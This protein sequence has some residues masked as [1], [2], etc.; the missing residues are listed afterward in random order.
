MPVRATKH[1]KIDRRQFG[2]LGAFDPWLDVDSPLFVDPTLLEACTIPEFV[3]SRDLVLAHYDKI[4]RLLLLAKPESRLWSEAVRL[5]AFHEMPGLALGYSSASTQGGGIGADLAASIVATAKEIIDAGVE[6]PIIFEIVGLFEK[7][8]GPDRISDMTCRIL[9]ERIYAFS[10]RVFGQFPHV[11]KRPF[12]FGGRTYSLP[13]NPF[14]HQPVL[15]V[16]SGILDELPLAVDYDGIDTVCSFNEALR[17]R[18][19]AL[20]GADW[21]KNARKYNKPELKRFLLSQPELLKELVSGYR[22]V[23]RKSYDF[24]RDVLGEFLLDEV[25]EL[26]EAKATEFKALLSWSASPTSPPLD[27]VKEVCE[28]VK[29]MVE[30]K[31]MW[32]LLYR[33][34]AY[35]EPKYEE[36]AQILFGGL[37]EEICNRCDVDATREPETGRG[38]V[39]FKFSRGARG[40]VLVETKLSTN[41][42]LVHA[43]DKQVQIYQKAAGGEHSIIVVFIVTEDDKHVK[44]LID[45]ANNNQVPGKTPSIILIDALPKPSASKA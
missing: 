34:S 32:K 44:K 40:K 3:D 42:N 17:D 33:D 6:D 4:F 26:F 22:M 13:L 14:K 23:K 39:D 15:L 2:K 38:P 12:T 36:A 41:P 11:P 1:F 20:L 8:I 5:V 9:G 25:R 45:H 18:L 19:N 29:R 35:K 24:L 10:E 16:P 21:V 30:E 28:S 37:A 31:E 7:G 43:F 27:V